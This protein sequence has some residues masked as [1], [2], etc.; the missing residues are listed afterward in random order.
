MYKHTNSHTHKQ[1]TKKKGT[2]L[3]NV[4][5]KFYY[6]DSLLYILF[7]VLFKFYDCIQSC[8]AFYG[9]KMINKKKNKILVTDGEKQTKQTKKEKSFPFSVFDHRIME[10]K[11]Y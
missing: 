3:E 10:Y 4:E 6:F 11:S 1:S 9:Q 2:K 8:L 5:T 7:Y